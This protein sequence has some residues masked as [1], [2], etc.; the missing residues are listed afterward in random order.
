MAS[1]AAVETVFPDG[2]YV[3]PINET[4]GNPQ[5]S[6]GMMHFNDGSIYKGNWKNGH[7]H[8]TGTC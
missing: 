6:D 7:M 4:T 8:G 3:G 5:G 1:S 2:I